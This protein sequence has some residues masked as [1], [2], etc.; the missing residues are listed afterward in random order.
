[1]TETLSLSS[2]TYTHKISGVFES[3]ALSQELYNDS[4]TITKEAIESLRQERGEA[5]LT[6]L[7]AASWKNDLSALQ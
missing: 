2:F 3:G 7:E 6:M 1:M 4:L 5:N